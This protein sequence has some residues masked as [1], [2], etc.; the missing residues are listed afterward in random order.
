MF[1]G[2]AHGIAVVAVLPE[3]L[4]QE[5][6]YPRTPRGRSYRPAG[7]LRSLNH[8]VRGGWNEVDPCKT[9]EIEPTDLPLV[10]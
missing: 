7:R 4:A 6:R 5:T 8:S 2:S 1:T 9:T 10:A 3:T